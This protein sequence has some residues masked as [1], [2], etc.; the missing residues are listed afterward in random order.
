MNQPVVELQDAPLQGATLVE[1]QAVKQLMSRIADVSELAFGASELVHLARTSDRLEGVQKLIQADPSLVAQILRRLNSPYY[2]LNTEIQDLA[3]ATRLLGFR[4]IR[5]LAITVYLSRM[6]ER[7]MEYGTFSCS[8]LWS[9]SVA[10]AVASQLMSR[11]CGCGDPADAFVAGLLHDIGLLLASRQMRRHFLKV[12]DS[13]TRLE[14]T[15]KME[16]HV[17]RFDHAQLGAFVADHWGFPRPVVDSIRFHHDVNS[18]RGNHRSIVSVVAIAN[19]LC[20]RAGW[21]AMGVHNVVVPIDDVY[22]SLGLDEV[23]LAVVW[24]QLARS[25]ENASFLTQ[26]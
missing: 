23:A 7:P 10:V 19:Y 8:G 6:F 21:T 2:G 1:S 25:L 26:N 4:E 15:A 16:H 11:V 14:P 20:S 18:Y 12:I 13:V 3:A 5:N 24:E 17:Y 9:H 22:E